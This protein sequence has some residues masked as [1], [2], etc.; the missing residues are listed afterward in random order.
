MKIGGDE[1]ET[2]ANNQNFF[3]IIRSLFIILEYDFIYPESRKILE[4]KR[5]GF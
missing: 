5:K 1:Q 4:E 3:L 2:N